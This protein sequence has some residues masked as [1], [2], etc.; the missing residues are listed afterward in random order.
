[1]N[2]KLGQ[3]RNILS[4]SFPKNFGINIS[5]RM[6]YHI[7]KAPDLMPRNLSMRGNKSL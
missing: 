7:P 1:M 6:G 3:P 2:T 5:I 4:Y